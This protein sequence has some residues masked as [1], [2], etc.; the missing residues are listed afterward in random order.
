MEPRAWRQEKVTSVNVPNIIMGIIAKVKF[1][2]IL[3]LFQLSL[4]NCPRLYQTCQS[5]IRSADLHSEELS[6]GN[7]ITIDPTW[8]SG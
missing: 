8:L 3:S 6:L 1:G 4:I 7:V 2:Y 5:A